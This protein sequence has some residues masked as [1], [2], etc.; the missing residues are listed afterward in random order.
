MKVLNPMVLMLSPESGEAEVGLGKR[1]QLYLPRLRV[2]EL[3]ITCAWWHTPIVL[4]TLRLRE[5]DYRS[6][7]PQENY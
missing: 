4:D 6:R 7:A 5:K 2:Y 1:C 3:R